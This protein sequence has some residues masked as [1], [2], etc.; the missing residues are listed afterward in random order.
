MFG[1]KVFLRSSN[2]PGIAMNPRLV[3]NYCSF[4]FNILSAAMFD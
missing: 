2:W 3:L 1:H 4:C